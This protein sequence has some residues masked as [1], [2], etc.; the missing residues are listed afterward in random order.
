MSVIEKLKVWRS[1]GALVNTGAGSAL[2]DGMGGLVGAAAA[3]G[4]GVGVDGPPPWAP[5]DGPLA[6]ARG[7]LVTTAGLHMPD[8]QPFD[9]DIAEGDTSFREIPSD[10]DLSR[11]RVSHTH[12]PH[13]RVEQDPNVILP[14]QRLR[15]LVAAEVIGGLGPRCFSFGFGGYQ[16]EPYLRQPD[17]SAHQVARKLLEDKVDFA[18]LVPA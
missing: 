11:L 9:V 10:C 6:D 13:G 3:L 8:D 7:V 15:E 18:L 5:F 1:L 2:M 12:Y 4:R 17:G 14:L 16:T